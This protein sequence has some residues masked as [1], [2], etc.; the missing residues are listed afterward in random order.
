AQGAEEAAVS[1]NT[2]AATHHR[3]YDDGGQIVAKFLDETY[4]SLDIVVVREGEWEGEIQRRTAMREGQHAAMI[5]LAE[6]QDLRP[7]ADGACSRQRH[8]VGFR[9]GIAEA[10]PLDGREP[11]D[12]RR[13]ITRLVTIGRAE[14][15]ALVD[16]LLERRR[17]D[18]VGV[19]VE[20]G[21]V[22]GHEVDIAMAVE[23]GDMAT[24]TEDERQREGAIP[25][26]CAGIASGQ[27]VGCIL[28]P[29]QALGIGR[30][31]TLPRIGENDV[32]AGI[33][34]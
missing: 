16:D 33:A 9:A 13:S 17:D 19:A 29:F 12:D 1:R 34:K 10:H 27:R 20:P 8:D 32:E 24:I 4:G 30:S 15:E 23:I 28:V 5:A 14:Q 11:L 2:A 7:A 18:L 6:R 3:F 22:L 25:E 26:H 21:A 31:E